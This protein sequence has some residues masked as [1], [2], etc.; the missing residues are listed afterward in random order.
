MALHVSSVSH[1]RSNDTL[2]PLLVGYKAL[3]GGYI[4][5]FD[6]EIKDW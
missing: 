4:K 5:R 1:L 6:Y 3:G 2:K